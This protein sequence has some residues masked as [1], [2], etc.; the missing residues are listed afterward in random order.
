MANYIPEIS[1]EVSFY[2]YLAI[3]VW[4]GLTYLFK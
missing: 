1:E 2:E 3:D 4:P